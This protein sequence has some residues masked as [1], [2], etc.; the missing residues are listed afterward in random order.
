M[1]SPRGATLESLMTLHGAMG[2]KHKILWLSL[3]RKAKG[4]G[5]ISFSTILVK[6]ILPPRSCW[7]S[8]PTRDKDDK[9]MGSSPESWCR[10]SFPQ[11]QSW[12]KTLRSI[13]ILISAKK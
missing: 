11:L 5:K 13:S 12:Y 8:Q 9:E 10:L 4:S 6:M 2:A 7:S 1:A 3:P